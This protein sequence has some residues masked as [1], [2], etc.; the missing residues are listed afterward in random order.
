MAEEDAFLVDDA[1]GGL[2]VD[3]TDAKI[4]GRF[5]SGSNKDKG[6]LRSCEIH[7]NP[8]TWQ[9]ILQGKEVAEPS[10]NMTEEGKTKNN[11]QNKGKKRDFKEHGSGP[12]SNK[13]PKLQCW[14]CGKTGHFKR[15]CRSSNKKNVNAGGSGKGLMQLRGGLIPMLQLMLVKIVAGLRHMNRWTMDLPKD[16]IPNSDESQR[17]DHYDDVPSEITEPRKGKRVWKPKSYGF[18][19]LL[20]F[21][22][23]LRDQVGLQYLY[24]Y[25]IEEDLRTYNE[26]LQSRD[27][28]FWKEEIDDE[29]DQNQVDK[30]KKFLSSKFSM[31]DIGE[32]DAILVS[33]PMD[34]VEKLKPNTG[35]P[36]DQLKYSRAIGCLMYAMTSTRPD[37]AYA[38][39]ASWIN[40]VEDSSST[41]GWVF[42]LSGGAISWASKKQ[43]ASLVLLWNLI[44]WHWLLLFGDSYQAPLEETG[45]GLVSESSAKKKGRTVAITT[46]DM[47]KRRND[48]K[49]ITTLLLAILDEHQLRFSKYETSQEL[50]GAILKTFGGNKATK[51]K[52]E[53]VEA[54]ICSGKGKVHTA[55]VPTASTQVSTASTNVTAAS[56]SH[57]INMTLLSMRADR[58]WKKTGKK[59][60]IQGSDVAGFDKSK[61]ECFNCH[62]MGHFARECRAPRS[63]DKGKKECYRQ[64]PKEEEHAP[65]ALMAIDGIGWDWSYMANEEENH[66]LVADE[67]VLT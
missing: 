27:V 34:P 8:S 63:Q 64:G 29:I 10:V 66:A 56:I 46:E 48:V 58:F 15:D 4:D 39:D 52:E 42:L 40:H 65:K 18:D 3:N 23:G 20:Y 33:T 49:V 17:D 51:K 13:K 45:K 16:I 43:H 25:T 30:T 26:A 41:S 36:V 14:K 47:Q 62:K 7:L 50:W 21:V 35:K 60:T 54:T 28:A 59:I 1:E 11:K 37:I 19:F 38:V 6:K 12:G 31:K 32:A 5:N 22:E 2:C 67:E 9:R 44:L 53:S 55:S 57:D 24:C 61:V